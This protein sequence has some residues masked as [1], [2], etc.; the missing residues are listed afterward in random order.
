MAKR[1][2]PSASGQYGDRL[3]TTGELRQLMSALGAAG[4]V[5]L[6]AANLIEE[7][8][9]SG[10]AGAIRQLQLLPGAWRL[11]FRADALSDDVL[12]VLPDVAARLEEDEPPSPE[13]L[14]GSRS[15]MVN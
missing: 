7:A 9:A 12:D 5:L 4:A 13:M 10:R 8:I 1:G 2:K 3:L 11:G 6:E 15:P 14:L